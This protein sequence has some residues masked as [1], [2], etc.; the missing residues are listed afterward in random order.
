M[1]T[2]KKAL[3]PK[4]VIPKSDAQI[5]FE[6]HGALLERA[7]QKRKVLLF[8]IIKG[9]ET[10]HKRVAEESAMKS[11][12]RPSD[13]QEAFRAERLLIK[14]KEDCRLA[15]RLKK[16]LSEMIAFQEKLYALATELLEEAQ[17]KKA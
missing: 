12:M 14:Y 6:E 7:V 3:K 11:K 2:T 5:D 17:H 9:I 10:K 13:K 15:N 8:K 1:A 16:A 4:G